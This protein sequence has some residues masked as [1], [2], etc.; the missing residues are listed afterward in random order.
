MCFVWIS[1]Q[2]AIITQHSIKRLV[3]ITEIECVYCAVRAGPLNRIQ[4]HIEVYLYSF[5]GTSALNGVGNQ[6]QAS[7][8]STSGKH[9][10]P[11]IQEVGPRAGL[12]GRKISSQPRFDP[13]P[14][15]P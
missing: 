14:S 7:A 9:P 8:N 13:E 12:N 15:S 1:G 3:F 5:L 4:A 11:I 10:E 2:T 6:P